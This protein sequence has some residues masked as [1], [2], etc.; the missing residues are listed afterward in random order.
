M[1]ADG[2]SKETVSI[3]HQYWNL[4]GSSFQEKAMVAYLCTAGGFCLF[5]QHLFLLAENLKSLHVSWS[6]AVYRSLLAL[7]I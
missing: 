7:G 1:P 5:S 4:R 3:N 6:A 2:V